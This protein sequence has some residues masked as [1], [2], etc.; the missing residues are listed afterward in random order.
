MSK[1]ILIVDD[2]PVILAAARHALTEAGYVVETCTGVEEVSAHGAKGFDLIL[3]DVQMP[4]LFGDDVAAVLKF[5]R[6]VAAPIY[7]FSTL[8]AEEL[9]ERAREAKVD[10]FIAKGAGTEH[11]VTEVRRILG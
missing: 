11:L 8:P 5:E 3:M 1:R 4:E 7:L 6:E 9:E 2:S 10:G